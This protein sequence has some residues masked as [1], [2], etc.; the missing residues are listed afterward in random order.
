MDNLQNEIIDAATA[1]LA[2]MDGVQSVDTA[3][4]HG[5]P[6]EGHMFTITHTDGRKSH[7]ALRWA[8]GEEAEA[9]DRLF[10][11]QKKRNGR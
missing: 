2:F 1:G 6:E 9:M 3:S 4:L 10:D 7:F 5:R 8:H 11:E